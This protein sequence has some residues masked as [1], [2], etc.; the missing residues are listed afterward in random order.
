MQW[1]AWARRLQAISQTGIAYSKDPH[2]LERF[3]EVRQIVAE[4]F[5]AG[6]GADLS[7]LL[8]LFSGQVGYATPKVDTRGVVFRD[9][10]ILMVKEKSDHRWTLPGGWADVGESPSEAV[11]KEILEEAGLTCKAVKLLAVHDGNKRSQDPDHIFHVYKLFIRCEILSGGAV[12]GIETEAV[13]FFGEDDLPE[14]SV[15]RASSAQI[16]RMF[17]HDRNPE[18]PADFD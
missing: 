11:T 13:G 17:E 4:I 3:L 5:A 6:G 2:H 18:W 15:P 7:R 12:P 10:R 8:D 14:L 9:G 1:L 16:R